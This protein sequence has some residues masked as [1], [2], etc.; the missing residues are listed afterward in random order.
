[1]DIDTLTAALKR[2]RWT[3]E[4]ACQAF[5]AMLSTAHRGA[6]PI[7]VCR[8]GLHPMVPAN[9]RGDGGCRACAAFREKARRCGV[10]L[11]KI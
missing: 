9:R 5:E 4:D 7:H 6:I 11:E 8:R 2:Q 1:M 3:V 10:V